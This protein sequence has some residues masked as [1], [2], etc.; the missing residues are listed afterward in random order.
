MLQ[1]QTG[2]KIGQYQVEGFLGRG[3]FA[4]VFLATD[5]K[6]RR[7]A[8]KMGDDS[9]GGRFLPRFGEVTVTRDPRALSPDETPAEA[10][11]LDPVEGARSEVLNAKEI[12][13]LLIQEAEMLRLADGNSVP[14]LHEILYVEERPVLVMD[15]IPG[16]T[17]RER[18]RSMEGVKLGW[19]LEAAQIVQRNCESGW[20]CHGDIKPENIIITEQEEVILIDPVAK[21]CREDS[22]VTTPWYNPFLRWDT[23]GDAQSFAIILYELMIGAVPFDQVPWSM[24]GTCASAHS[25]EEREMSLSLYLA[26]PPMREL[27]V[28]TPRYVEQMFHRAMCDSS[29]DLAELVSDLEEFLLG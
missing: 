22:I 15:H 13:D 5:P 19:I 7:V 29:Y 17:L 2:Q 10:M 3:A 11:F 25:E 20:T 23:K 1:I 12:D 28:L 21:A 27:N 9:G 26:Y 18:I 16:T 6:G 4:Q 24:A 14:R 8:L